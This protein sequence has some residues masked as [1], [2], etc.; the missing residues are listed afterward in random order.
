MMKACGKEDRMMSAFARGIVLRGMIL[1]AAGALS[2]SAWA[3]EFE[4][5]GDEAKCTA[6]KCTGD[7]SACDVLSVRQDGVNQDTGAHVI[8][9]FKIPREHK[10]QSMDLTLSLG[11]QLSDCKT[12]SAREV[13]ANANN[14][15]ARSIDG[16]LCRLRATWTRY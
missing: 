1:L 13:N 11:E 8:L 16:F 4:C 10:P 3:F 15:D 5:R 6:P 14:A 2:P 12:G 7:E 9:I